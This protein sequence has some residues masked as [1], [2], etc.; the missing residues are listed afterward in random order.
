MVRVPA[1]CNFSLPP[2]GEI[3]SSLVPDDLRA[4]AYLAQNGEA[5]WAKDDALRV[6]RWAAEVQL[7]IVGVEVW[8][9]TNPGPTIP[10]PFIYAFEPRPI[11][12][13]SKAQFDNRA[14]REAAH[15][16]QSF[17]WD[18]HDMAH[19]GIEPFFNITFG[20]D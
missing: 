3:M 6:I 16:V 10:T 2:N 5:A 12:G 9:P 14:N 19:H 11:E 7:P 8:L 18:P 13:E 15:Y 20:A 17:E 1:T 4:S